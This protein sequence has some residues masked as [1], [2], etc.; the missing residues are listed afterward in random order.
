M[1]I[2]IKLKKMPHLAVNA[3]NALCPQTLKERTDFDANALKAILAAKGLL[4][5][6]LKDKNLEERNPHIFE[7]IQGSLLNFMES[8]ALSAVERVEAGEILGQLGDPRF[9]SDLFFSPQ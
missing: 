1:N 6:G 8:G 3:I 5:V 7:N 2:I 9:N 4:E